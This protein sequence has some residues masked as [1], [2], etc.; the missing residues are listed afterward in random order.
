[1]ECTNVVARRPNNEIRQICAETMPADH[2]PSVAFFVVRPRRQL[3]PLAG[4][5]PAEA[6]CGRGNLKCINSLVDDQLDRED[7]G[8]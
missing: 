4:S 6:A 5:H 2:S 3:S 8:K 7:A 1:V